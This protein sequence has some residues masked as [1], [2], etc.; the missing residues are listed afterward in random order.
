MRFSV[1]YGFAIQIDHKIIFSVPE[2]P[3]MIFIKSMHYVLTLRNIH[4]ITFGIEG[5]IKRFPIV[6]GDVTGSHFF[7]HIETSFHNINLVT[8]AVGR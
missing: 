7:I 8:V 4:F 5:I 3:G 2:S 6:P 1:P